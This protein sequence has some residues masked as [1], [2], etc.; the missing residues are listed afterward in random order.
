[1][2]SVE[3]ENISAAPREL[4]AQHRPAHLESRIGIA[5]GYGLGR[6]EL[7]AR[8]ACAHLAVSGPLEGAHTLVV[9]RRVPAVHRIL[10]D[11]VVAEEKRP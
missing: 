3:D 4:V 11:E 2:A 8:T 10:P 9:P 7:K 5:Q 6:V 1:M